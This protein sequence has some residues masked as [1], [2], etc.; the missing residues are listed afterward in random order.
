MG[1]A[2]PWTRC[3]DSV[4]APSHEGPAT[5]ARAHQLLEDCQTTVW[6]DGTGWLFITPFVSDGY[7]AK[8]F[9]GSLEVRTMQVC[10][11]TMHGGRTAIHDR[12]WSAALD[13]AA[14]CG[15]NRVELIQ[16]DST[17]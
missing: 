10:C 7:V 3:L 13:H 15:L 8:A 14:T 5:T 17:L 9:H 4:F 11:V 2:K 12:S 6:N 16:D 1:T